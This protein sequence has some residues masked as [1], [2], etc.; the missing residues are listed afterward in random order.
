M[1]PFIDQEVNHKVK[2]DVFSNILNIK[3][4][5]ICPYEYAYHLMVAHHINK[6]RLDCKT[7]TCKK[8]LCRKL[9]KPVKKTAA[10]KKATPK[11]PAAAA[12]AK[13]KA[14]A[15]K[16]TKKPAKKPTAKK[17]AKKVAK[18][19]TKK[20]PAATSSTEACRGDEVARRG[21]W[22]NHL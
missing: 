7:Q 2:S 13:K 14:P 16:T 11:K 19:P 10:K 21:A 22:H 15:K 8:Y 5:T 6:P 17:P 12:A 18:K 1:E 4:A 9:E 20:K 3:I